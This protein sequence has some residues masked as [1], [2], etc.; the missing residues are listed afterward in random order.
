MVFEQRASQCGQFS[1]LATL[2]FMRSPAMIVL[3]SKKII[4]TYLQKLKSLDLL[5]TQDSSLKK[6]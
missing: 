5:M 1:V 6:V 4:L 2:K 3:S